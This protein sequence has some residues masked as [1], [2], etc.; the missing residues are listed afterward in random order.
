MAEVP[1][2]PGQQETITGR[3]VNSTGWY[4]DP[5]SGVI[6][7]VS[8]PSAADALVKLGWNFLQSAPDPFTHPKEADKFV[9][10][11]SDKEEKADQPQ[12][13]PL[14][15]NTQKNPTAVSDDTN[16]T[17][18]EDSTEGEDSYKETTLANG[19]K[20]YYKNGTQ[21]SAEDYQEAVSG[22]SNVVAPGVVAPNASDAALKQDNASADATA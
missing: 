4:K 17:S 20:R 1:Q 19:S 21:I 13:N 5:E 7:H 22:T 16:V 12:S 8:H 9:L 3:G 6:Q 14:Q 11:N 18:E 10:D 2:G 15:P